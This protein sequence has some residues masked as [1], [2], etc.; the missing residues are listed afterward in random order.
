MKS[1]KKASIPQKKLVKATLTVIS[2]VLTICSL[3]VSQPQ[4]VH[5]APSLGE[6][7]KILS[8]QIGDDLEGS[9][10]TAILN[11]KESIQLMIF[12]LTNEKIIQ[13]LRDQAERGILT[14]VICDA[15]ASPHIVEKLGPS[16]QI[17][18]RLAKGLMHLKILVIDGKESWIGSA[19]FTD[20]SLKMHGNLVI[21]FN[22]ALLAKTLA[23]KTLTLQEY[24]RTG[25]VLHQSYLIG[26]QKVELSFLPDDRKGC[27][28]IKELIRAAKKTIKIAMFTWTRFDLAK[29]VISAKKRGVQVEVVLDNNSAKGASSKVAELLKKEHIPTKYSSAGAALLHHKF[30]WI[31]DHILE[32]GSA[33]WTKAAFSQN[34][35]CFLI[36]HQLT[37]DQQNQMRKV[38]N[39]IQSDA[40]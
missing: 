37:E 12:S 7:A 14:K 22:N 40:R 39:A 28:R 27:T 15:K 23:E 24:Q 4:M 16:V 18:R 35:D 26:E 1:R 19:N 34:D 29:E 3:W 13:A 8:N 36:F 11:A 9:Y 10:R 6:S 20:E 32:I 30:L 33:N 25:E 31:D 2:V 21:A 5:T 17:V 38:W